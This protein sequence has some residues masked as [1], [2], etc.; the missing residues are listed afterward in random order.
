MMPIVSKRRHVDE[1][2]GQVVEGTLSLI[3]PL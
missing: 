1:E 3:G 2:T